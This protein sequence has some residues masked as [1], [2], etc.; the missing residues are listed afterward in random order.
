M[1]TWSTANGGSVKFMAIRM[2]GK[3]G[4]GMPQW[5]LLNQF[6]Q[7]VH[8]AFGDWPYLVGSALSGKQWRDVDVRLILDDAAYERLLGKPQKPAIL[9]KAW[10]AHCLAFSLLGKHMTGLP[11]D[12][13]IQTS[14]E[15]NSED[16]HFK[17]DRSCLMLCD[18]FVC[19]SNKETAKP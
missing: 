1:A 13:Q 15:A 17:G 11:I 3:V 16:P 7:L 12:F 2:G 5:I 14:S 8:D 19:E 6:G 9:N 4:V 10:A 18:D